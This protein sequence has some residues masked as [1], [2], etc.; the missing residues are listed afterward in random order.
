MNLLSLITLWLD[1]VYQIKRKYYSSPKPKFLQ[2]KQ[3]LK[4][5]EFLIKKIFQQ[6][7]SV[8]IIIKQLNNI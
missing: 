2:T 1:N 3:G 8:I 6:A 4:S 7:S 5:I